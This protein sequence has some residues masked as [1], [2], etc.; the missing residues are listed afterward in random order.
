MSVIKRK[1]M[2]MMM[3]VEGVGVWK[4]ALKL[5]QFWKYFSIVTDEYSCF[6]VRV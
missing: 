3:M 4:R 2:M 1:L 6:E 5:K